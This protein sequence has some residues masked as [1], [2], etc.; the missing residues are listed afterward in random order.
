MKHLQICLYPPLI[1]L[2][3]VGVREF[4]CLQPCYTNIHAAFLYKVKQ[5]IHLACFFGVNKTLICLTSN[6]DKFPFK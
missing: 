6:C 2:H 1:G 4:D 3:L 5:R